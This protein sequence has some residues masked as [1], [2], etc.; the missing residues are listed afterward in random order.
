M[1]GTFIQNPPCKLKKMK[2]RIVL[3]STFFIEKVFR[4]V[5]NLSDFTKQKFVKLKCCNISIQ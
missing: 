1:G 3:V 4:G 5:T 2:V